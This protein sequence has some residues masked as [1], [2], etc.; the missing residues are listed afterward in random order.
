MSDEPQRMFT[1][2]DAPDDAAAAAGPPAPGRIIELAA[3]FMVSKTLFAAIELGLFAAAGDAGGTPAEL[4]ERCAI[5]ERSARAMAD[6]LA[7]AGLLVRD[8]GRF[9]N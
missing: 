2:T 1:P 7:D 4:A 9:R 6:L 8:G 5:P 3:G